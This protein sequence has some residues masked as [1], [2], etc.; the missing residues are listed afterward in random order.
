M[1]FV[2]RDSLGLKRLLNGPNL[3][4]VASL[5]IHGALGASMPLLSKIEAAAP[6]SRSPERV[7]VIA[8][9]ANETARLPM[10]VLNPWNGNTGNWTGSPTNPRGGD[11]DSPPLPLPSPKNGLNALQLPPL[12]SPNWGNWG[13]TTGFNPGP[14]TG[15]PSNFQP[16][17][18]PA[19]PG[20]FSFPNLP[21][22]PAN[23]GEFLNTPNVTPAQVRITPGA[24]QALGLPQPPPPGLGNGQIPGPP[25]QTGQWLSIN[26]RLLEQDVPTPP[27][28]ANPAELL[29]APQDAPVTDRPTPETPT[30]GTNNRTVA[31][32]PEQTPPAPPAVFRGL[33]EELRQRR[34]A[35][36]FDPKDTG[37]G[38]LKR[39][40]EQW[41]K[42]W[43][44]TSTQPQTRT[45]NG[46]YPDDAC[47]RQLNGVAIYG[48][49][50]NTQGQ[51]G[52]LTL[53]QS[54]GYES[55]NRQAARQIQNLRVMPAPANPTPYRLRVEFAYS[56]QQCPAYTQTRTPSASP[57]VPATTSE[58]PTPPPKP[59]DVAPAVKSEPAP[60]SGTPKETAKPAERPPAPTKAPSILKPIQ[61]TISPMKIV[62]QEDVTPPP[63][64]GDPAQLLPTPTDDA[65]ADAPPT[66]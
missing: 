65:A 48:T 62:P 25:N 3:A 49:T 29:P 1:T 7:G 26:P 12:G 17:P 39:N 21:P 2:S 45:L 55:F 30:R 35:L 60:K 9:S 59:V 11:L 52:E 37:S 16:I 33:K 6:R 28:P 56:A 64:P 61:P 22:P 5:A 46:L 47:F 51:T 50:V 20:N 40:Y 34:L 23:L 31:I 18:L 8:L 44:T 57:P 24:Q 53:L 4:I 43:P 58:R 14:L 13:N 32:A 19:P 66:P 15:S 42:Q 54:S 27:I 36:Q 38:D 63:P 10:E 41:Q